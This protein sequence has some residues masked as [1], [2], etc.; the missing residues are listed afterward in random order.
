M[1]TAEKLPDSEDLN[2]PSVERFEKKLREMTPQEQETAITFLFVLSK[3]KQME[4]SFDPTDEKRFLKLPET[5]STGT[6]EYIEKDG[7]R[8]RRVRP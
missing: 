2:I 7:V 5:I 3:S 1:A 6:T 4:V 8:L